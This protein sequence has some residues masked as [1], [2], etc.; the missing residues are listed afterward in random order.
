MLA[1]GLVSKCFKLGTL[2]L[3]SAYPT[4]PFC[5]AHTL[6]LLVPPSLHLCVSIL[7]PKPQDLQQSLAYPTMCYGGL[8]IGFGGVLL[9]SIDIKEL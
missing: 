2:R 5:L 9:E 7:N 1:E 6:P 4:H 3:C 8:E